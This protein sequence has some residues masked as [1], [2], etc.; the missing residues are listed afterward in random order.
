MHGSPHQPAVIGPAD[1]FGN[2]PIRENMSC[3]NLPDNVIHVRIEISSVW[4]FHCL[5]ILVYQEQFAAPPIGNRCRE[6]K[7]KAVGNGLS[8]LT[9][10]FPYAV[11]TISDAEVNLYSLDLLHSLGGGG[12]VAFGTLHLGR[13]LDIELN[14]GFCA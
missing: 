4:A 8:A 7:N 3:R 12:N 9:N 2:M 10:A 11:A 5:S 1:E 13:H 14:L 6:Q